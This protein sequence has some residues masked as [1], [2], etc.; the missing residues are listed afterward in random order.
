MCWPWV[1]HLS[2]LQV[3]TA[4]IAAGKQSEGASV[5]VTVW[6]RGVIIEFVVKINKGVQISNPDNKDVIYK[7][8]VECW[9]SH[10]II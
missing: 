1:F 7:S 8:Q 6:W 4:D 5:A 9:L 10:T 2:P 3:A